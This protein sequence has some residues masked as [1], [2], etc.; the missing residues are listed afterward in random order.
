MTVFNKKCAGALSALILAILL[1]GCGCDHEWQRATCQ[2][3]RTCNRC[4]ETEGKIRSHEWAS[5]DCRAPEG[6]IVC[7]TL[8]GIELTH[9]WQKDCK[10]C[11]H[12]GHDE[13][14]ADDRFP[15]ALAAGLEQRWQLEEALQ[16]TEDY[17]LTKEDWAAFFAAE[18]DRLL[19]F[20]EEK[21][22]DK[23]MEDAAGRYIRSLE[24]SQK[25]LEH[26]GTEQWEDA[27]YNSAYQ[28]QTVALMYVNNL[29]P[30]AVSEA[31]AEKLEN[32][33]I[34]GEI[35]DLVSPLFDQVLF[36]HIGTAGETKR[37][38]TTLKN[39]SSLKFRWFSFDVE[40]KDAEGQTLETKTI[41]VLNWKP[42][43]RKRF[44]FSTTNDFAAV[45]VTFA[46]W[47][48]PR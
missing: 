3:P 26:F 6:C 21:F 40:L 30:V 13:R 22:Q 15:E 4:G 37:Y 38:E 25:A 39:T 20:R 17:V 44:Q 41:K 24:D 19:P 46:D 5:T 48:L 29:R 14:P 11:I 12:C 8:E 42:D 10:I 2:E 47:E 31:Y 16:E 23:A 27:Y 18:Y 9:E 35:I 7:G 45:D 32:M 1:T 36:L 43:E 28:A 34:N 33:L